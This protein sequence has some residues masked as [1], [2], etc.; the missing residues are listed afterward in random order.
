MKL[1]EISGQF[2]EIWAKLEESEGEITPEIEEMM[3]SIE[4]AFAEKI[5]NIIR[6]VRNESGSVSAIEEEIKRLQSRK[7]RIE[8]S[9]D[10]LKAYVKKN[11][12]LA[13]KTEVKT[14]LFTVRIQRIKDAVDVVASEKVPDQYKSFLLKDVPP[15][16]VEKTLQPYID[17][18]KVAKD[19]VLE[20]SKKGINIP[21][22]EIRPGTC[23]RIY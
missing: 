7:K 15:H 16:L 17:L 9:I 8:S 5:D 2:E 22:I 6:L 11:M 1:Y 18:I 3:N 12:E 14:E 10:W 19:K 13:K 21:G 23:L 4:G 20:D